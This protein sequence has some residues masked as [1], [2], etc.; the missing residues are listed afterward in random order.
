MLGLDG[1]FVFL[2]HVFWVVSLNTLFILLF[3]YIPHQLGKIIVGS[4]LP[5]TE[6]NTKYFHFEGAI[7]TV[8]GKSGVTKTRKSTWL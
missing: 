8:V 5:K 2:E 7:N 1:S 6:P 4:F 3:A